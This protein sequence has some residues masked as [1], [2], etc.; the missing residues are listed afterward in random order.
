M[1]IVIGEILIDRFPN[2]ER[3]GGA[4]F[5]FAF[6]LKQMGFAVRFITRIGEDAQG[7]AILDKI[8][9]SG[10]DPSDIQ[11]DRQHPT[12]TVEVTLDEAGVPDFDIRRN[13]AYDHIDLPQIPAEEKAGVRMF[14]FGSLV[15]RTANGRRQVQALLEGKPHTA[16]CFCDINLR[17]P[18]DHDDAI[19]GC[20]EGADILKLNS[21]ELD[22]ICRRCNGPSERDAALNWLMQTYTLKTVAMTLGAQGSLVKTSDDRCD[23]AP[24]EVGTIADT[25]GAGDAYAA[26]LAAGILHGW[27]MRRTLELATRFAADIC[28]LPGALPADDVPY[29]PIRKQMERT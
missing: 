8:E 4:P 26:V 1:I 21:D 7:A 6:H 12:G 28:T 3:I 17:P 20:L 2:Y 23:A 16:M 13:V 14:Y 27:P 11:I 24:A 18:H 5:N 29:I 10:F 19:F 9:Q 15:Q 25:V 22:E